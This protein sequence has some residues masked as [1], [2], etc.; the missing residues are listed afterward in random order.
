[1]SYEVTFF[2]LGG[3]SDWPVQ[4]ETYIEALHVAR[5]ARNSFAATHPGEGLR[6]RTM[7]DKYQAVRRDG[8]VVFQ[9]RVT[10]L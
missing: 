6:L 3:G 2:Q 5:D 8:T 1:M 7:K 4:C 10:P 9:A